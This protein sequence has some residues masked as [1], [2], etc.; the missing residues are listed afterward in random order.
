MDIKSFTTGFR[1]F[2]LKGTDYEAGLQY[3]TLLKSDLNAIYEEFEKFKE[4]TMANEIRYLPWYKRIIANLFGGM[5]WRHKIN[6]YAD[7]FSA[8]IEDQIRGAAEGSGLPETFFR[9][10]Q[11]VADLYSNRCEAIVI[12]K[13]RHILITVII[14]ISLCR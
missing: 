11:V 2:Y 10:I 7:R 4:R 13:G 12:K 8:N 9:E 1:F 6:S 14:S 5:V 3:G